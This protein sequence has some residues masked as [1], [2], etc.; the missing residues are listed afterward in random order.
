[1]ARLELF[2]FDM[3]GTTVEDHGDVFN[4]Y[5][6]T[7]AHCGLNATGAEVREWMGRKKRDV[8]EH[9]VTRKLGRESPG[10]AGEID[11]AYAYFRHCL[12]EHYRKSTVAAMP[13]AERVF[14]DLRGRGVKVALS[15]GF[16]RAV[17]DILL[18][19]LGWDKGLNAN[20]VGG[21]G[22]VIDASICADDVP[23]GRPAPYMIHEA[24]RRLGVLD[25]HGVG[26][27]GD[28]KV[29]LLSAYYAG[30]ALNVGVLSGACDRAKLMD[31]PHTHL[32]ASVADL[33]G[34][35]DDFLKVP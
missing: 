19:R 14:A 26:N 23:Q 13:G 16:Y 3:A 32:I 10:L 9:F 15:T 11:Q 7:I 4:A 12:E 31:S 24:M 20:H 30:C 22:S 18:A 6:E 35:V 34:V 33:P 2:V 29:D 21:E 17:A 1:M 5:M 28:T 25:V 8:F 27:A